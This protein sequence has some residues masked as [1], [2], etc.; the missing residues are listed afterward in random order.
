M[1]RLACPTFLKKT[2]FFQNNYGF[3]QSS[4]LIKQK[5]KVIY[6][7]TNFLKLLFNRFITQLLRQMTSGMFRFTNKSVF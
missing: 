5:L 3:A 4:E 1:Q 2:T 6:Q 7:G